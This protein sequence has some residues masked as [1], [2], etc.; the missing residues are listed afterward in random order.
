MTAK[1]LLSE[2]PDP[3]L[4]E[5]KEGLSGNLCRCGCYPAIAQ[6]T[7]RAAKKSMEGRR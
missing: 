5:V 3:T 6:A 2:N 7:L 4:E 1:G